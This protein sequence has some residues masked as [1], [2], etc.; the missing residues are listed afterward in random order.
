VLTDEHRSVLPGEAEHPTGRF[1]PV[2]P[3]R[4]DA[5]PGTVRAGAAVAT[6]EDVRAQG[7]GGA[8]LEVTM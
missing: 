7:E 4:D 3:G 1:R 8:Y 2:R 5:R 6:N